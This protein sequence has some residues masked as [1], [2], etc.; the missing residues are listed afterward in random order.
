[1]GKISRLYSRDDIQA[2]RW[3]VVEND[4]EAVA[5]AWLGELRCFCTESL[6]LS[7]I[8]RNRA[9]KIWHDI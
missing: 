5:A 2:M 3:R 8:P 9:Y 4:I 7:G 6:V 1:M